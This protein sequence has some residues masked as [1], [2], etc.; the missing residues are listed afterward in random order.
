[1]HMRLRLT[2]D[3]NSREYEGEINVMASDGVM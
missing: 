1:M 2:L 3:H